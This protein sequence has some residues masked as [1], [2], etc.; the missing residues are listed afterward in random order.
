VS[1]GIG[2]TF[3][4][5]GFAALGLEAPTFA[6]LDRLGDERTCSWLDLPGI[7]PFLVARP[8]PRY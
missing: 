1:G 4:G 7:S 2:G 3:F 6:E 8:I 5:A